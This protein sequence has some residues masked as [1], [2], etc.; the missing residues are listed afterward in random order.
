[1]LVQRPRLKVLVVT[2]VFRAS[3]GNSIQGRYDHSGN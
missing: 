2:D 3:T 1:M